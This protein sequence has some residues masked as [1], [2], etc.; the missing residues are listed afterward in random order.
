[1][2]YAE[3][4]LKEEKKKREEEEEEEDGGKHVHGLWKW[5]NGI[6]FLFQI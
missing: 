1:M 6:R 3:A 2:G 5:A 4:W